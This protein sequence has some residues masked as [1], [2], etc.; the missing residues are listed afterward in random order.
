LAPV[1]SDLAPPD[2][3]FWGAAKAKFYEDSAHMSD[4]L[5]TAVIQFTQSVT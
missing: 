1:S 4:E 5:K 3:F 2:L